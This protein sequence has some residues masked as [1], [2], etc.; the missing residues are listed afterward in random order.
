MSSLP[1]PH[2][3]QSS[4]RLPKLNQQFTSQSRQSSSTKYALIAALQ[5]QQFLPY[6]VEKVL[7]L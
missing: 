1:R 4:P 2:Y 5:H 6:F 3:R 7:L